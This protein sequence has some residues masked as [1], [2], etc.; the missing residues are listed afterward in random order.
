MGG[1]QVLVVGQ[2]GVERVFVIADQAGPAV[3]PRV[4]IVV[5]QNALERVK[6]AQPRM[7]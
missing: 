5:A 6:A 7:G 3:Q 2:H 1:P 4:E